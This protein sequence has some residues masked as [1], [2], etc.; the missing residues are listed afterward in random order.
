MTNI[1]IME[2]ILEHIKYAKRRN[3]GVLILEDEDMVDVVRDLVERDLDNKKTNKSIMGYSIIVCNPVN[4]DELIKKNPN[5]TYTV[6]KYVKENE[7]IC[8]NDWDLNYK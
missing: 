5:V 3:S 8:L 2:E 1:K 6:S 7:V 4:H